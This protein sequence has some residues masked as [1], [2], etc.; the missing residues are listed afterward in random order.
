MEFGFGSLYSEDALRAG[1]TTDKAD[2]L[3]AS[4]PF[5][6]MPVQQ[7]QIYARDQAPRRR[8]LRPRWS[9]PDSCSISARTNRA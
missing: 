2:L 4:M 1:I 8:L 5:G 9:G 7:A 3:F 6:L